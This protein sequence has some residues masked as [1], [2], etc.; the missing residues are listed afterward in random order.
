M[1]ESL[2]IANF[3]SFNGFQW[4]KSLVENDGQLVIFK[5]VNILYGRNY[6]GKTTLSRVF[7]SLETGELPPKYQF[8]SFSLKLDG[9]IFN[10]LMIPYVDSCIR[11]Y[12]KDFVD[13]NLGFLKDDDGNITS[14][15]ILGVDNNKIKK[16]IEDKEKKL[17]SIDA[18]NGL[19]YRLDNKTVEY[20]KKK[21]VKAK[22]VD[23]LKS[24]LTN[25]AT[26][27][28][29][30]IKHNTTYREANYNRP[31]IEADIKAIRSKLLKPLD[32]SNKS[33]KLSLLSEKAL[34][35]ISKRLIFSSDI[36]SICDASM[37][38]LNREIK[39]NNRHP[40]N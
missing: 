36:E 32:E 12:N 1:I 31:K 15:A 26:N 29:N 37:N 22:A 19:L 25:K 30:G 9:K 3:G 40:L 8:P 10:Q 7:G 21:T 11:V 34:P 18:E 16:E 14:F 33:L 28:E 13:K 27:S 2:D 24:K 39:N 5:K 20:T 38:L 6:S 4:K 35:D 23:N 17:G